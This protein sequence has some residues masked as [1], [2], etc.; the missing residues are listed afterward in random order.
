MMSGFLG[1]AQSLVSSSP[2]D[3]AR[4]GLTPS[5]LFVWS[6]GTAGLA[7]R[8][9]IPLYLSK[10]G[11][12]F[13]P[14]TKAERVF[15]AVEPHE[16]EGAAEGAADGKLSATWDGACTGAGAAGGA[17]GAGVVAGADAGVVGWSGATNVFGA[18]VGAAVPGLPASVAIGCCVSVVVS[19]PLKRT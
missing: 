15:S 7:A 12:E 18:A 1:A 9:F 4:T 5:A 6:N 8:L 2:G 14:G 17:A 19:V 16:S 13:S 10:S 11:N 3:C